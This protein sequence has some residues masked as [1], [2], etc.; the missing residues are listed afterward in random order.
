[1]V[2]RNKRQYDKTL[3]LRKIDEYASEGGASELG[4]FSHFHIL[5]CYF[6]QYSV[7]TS[8]TLSQKHILSGLILHLHT[9]TINA[10]PCYGKALYINDSIPTKH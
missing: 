5:K 1:M 9:Y 8:D 10:V 6:L 4:K 2:W 3:T 7:G